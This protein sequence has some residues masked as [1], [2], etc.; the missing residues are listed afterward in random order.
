MRGWLL[1]LCAMP[2]ILATIYQ[3]RSVISRP[4]ISPLLSRLPVHLHPARKMSTTFQHPDY[5]ISITLPAGLSQDKVLN[6]N[7]FTVS[8]THPGLFAHLTNT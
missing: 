3:S 6:F 1:T 4:W 5:N 8:R 2:I 7:P